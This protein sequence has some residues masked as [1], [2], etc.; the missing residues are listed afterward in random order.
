MS[1]LFVYNPDKVSG[2]ALCTL[3]KLKG[4][5]SIY[6]EDWEAIVAKIRFISSGVLIIDCGSLP[7]IFMLLQDLIPIIHTSDIMIILLTPFSNHEQEI[8]NLRQ[9]G[10]F[11]LEKP[12]ILN[13]LIGL[14]KKKEN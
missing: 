2:I 5:P 4:Q 11:L 3:L 14:I 12:V 7:D 6:Y 8:Q 10:Y 1:N 9:Q 13:E